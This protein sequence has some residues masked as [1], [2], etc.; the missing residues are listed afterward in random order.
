MNHPQQHNLIEVPMAFRWL[1]DRQ[2]AEGQAG[3]LDGHAAGKRAASRAG[4][5]WKN[6]AFV[7]FCAFATTHLSFLTEDVRLHSTIELPP[8]PRAW[9]QVAMRAA[10]AGVITAIG[11][12]RTNYRRSHGRFFT[13]W[14][15]N[16]YAPSF[17]E[18]VVQ[19]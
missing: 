1:P 10:R 7:E 3:L 15:S 8:D 12:A 5:E 18:S 13:Q 11:V 2:Q 4:M 19:P 9:G 14:K 16:V 17:G 6:A